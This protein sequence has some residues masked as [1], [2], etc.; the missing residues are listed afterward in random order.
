MQEHERV[1]QCVTT[2]WLQRD[3]VLQQIKYQA[4]GVISY[5]SHVRYLWGLEVRVWG[6]GF[7]GLV[8]GSSYQMCDIICLSMTNLTLSSH[9][10]GIDD[11]DEVGKPACRAEEDTSRICHSFPAGHILIWQP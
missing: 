9:G 3:Y 7:W 10:P 8:L 11:D 4:F 1:G 5:T 6:L 2:K